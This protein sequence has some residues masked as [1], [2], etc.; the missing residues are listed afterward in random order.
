MTDEAPRIAD[1]RTTVYRIPTDRPEADG[2]FQW[3]STTT[4]LPQVDLVSKCVTKVVLPTGDVVINDGGASNPNLHTGVA[5]YKEFWYTMV[6]LAGEGQNFD[7]NGIY[8]RFQPGGGSQTIST[9]KSSLSGD[10][11]FANVPEKPLGTRPAFPGT[12]PPYKP[13]VPCY[14]QKIPDLNGAATGKPDASSPNGTGGGSATVPGT[15]VS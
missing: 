15:P 14:T 5:N 1:L 11:L 4:L 9:G 13:D 7:G 2:T 8:V 10:T 6:G 3:D 12:R